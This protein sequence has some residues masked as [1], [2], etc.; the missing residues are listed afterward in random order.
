MR[1][2]TKEM[3]ALW[4]MLGIL[5][6]KDA[7]LR[8]ETLKLVWSRALEPYAWSD[9]HEA[10]LTHFRTQKYFPDVADITGRCPQPREPEALEAMRYRQ[11]TAGERQRTAEM[12]CRW[13]SYRAALEAAG[14][15]S[16]SQA[17]ANGMRCADWDAL[18]QGAGICLEDFLSAEESHA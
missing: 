4:E 11:P 18:T 13:R 2:N 10:V 15:P 6:P 12:V 7:R 9:V 5:R 3:D 16:L 17:Q 1:L 14:L 8:N